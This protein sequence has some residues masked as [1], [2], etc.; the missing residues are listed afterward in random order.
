MKEY[1]EKLSKEVIYDIMLNNANSLTNN[2][3][4]DI[5]KEI[6]K[7]SKIDNEGYE[8]ILN[9]L[10]NYTHVYSYNIEFEINYDAYGPNDESY[11]TLFIN[12]NIDD[13]LNFN[14]KINLYHI[15]LGFHYDGG[16]DYYDEI[17]ENEQCDFDDIDDSVIKEHE[18]F[19]NEIMK[20]Y[21]NYNFIKFNGYM[22]SSR[23]SRGVELKYDYEITTTVFDP[24]EIIN[25][26][27][28]EENT[29][30][31]K[32]DLYIKKLDRL[33]ENNKDIKY[34]KVND[35]ILEIIYRGILY[36]FE[37]GSLR[38]ENKINLNDWKKINKFY[39]DLINI[40][41]DN[42]EVFNLYHKDYEPLEELTK[43]ELIEELKKLKNENKY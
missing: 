16:Q 24:L 38:D 31:I 18:N 25:P 41:Y 11:Q 3:K 12:V 42:K 37:I 39:N 17:I 15:E 23:Y 43:E 13:R 7:I 21:K 14:K 8:K 5:I 33:L 19:I 29:N 36:K 1:I 10:K 28:N 32:D 40:N 22:E 34:F 30:I 20:I 9:L 26:Y 2:I 4:N 27:F 35:G 6:E